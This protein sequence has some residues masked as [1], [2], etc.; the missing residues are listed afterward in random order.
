MAETVT[1][2]FGGH[3]SP[4]VPIIAKRAKRTGTADQLIGQQHSELP[5]NHGVEL[6][7][8]VLR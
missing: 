3:S 6:A 5:R 4:N 8:I 1:S 2:V 7:F